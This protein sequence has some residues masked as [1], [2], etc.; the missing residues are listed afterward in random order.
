MRYFTPAEFN[1]DGMPVFDNMNSDLLLQLD[2]ARD[3]AGVPMVINSSYRTP[4][5]NA[6][7][8]GSETSSHLKGLAVDIAADTGSAKYA[9]LGGLIK[10]GFWRIGIGKNFIHADIDPDKPPGIIW[11]Y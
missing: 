10:A 9:I 6:A 11:L 7:V 4:E 1:I 3:I 2:I 5:K 8:G